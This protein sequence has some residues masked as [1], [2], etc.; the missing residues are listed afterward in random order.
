MSAGIPRP[1][2]TREA[3][4]GREAEMAVIDKAIS[5]EGHLRIVNIQGAGGIGKTSILREVQKRYHGRDGPLVTE[6]IDFFDISTH[7]WQGFLEEVVNE[8]SKKNGEP[9]KDYRKVRDR[10]DEIELAGITGPTLENARKEALEA[11]GSCYNGLAAKKRI[12]ILIDTF[13]VVQHILGKRLPEWLV[14]LE[15]TAVIIAGRRNRDW[16]DDL[17]AKVG[18]RAVDSLELKE[19]KLEDTEELFALSEAGRIISDEERRKLQRLSGGRPILLTL[20][21]YLQ[22]REA[23]SPEKLTATSGEYTLDDLKAMTTEELEQVQERFRVELVQRFMKLP[24]PPHTYIEMLPYHPVILYMGQVYK[25]FTVDTLTCLLEVTREEAQALLDGIV[26]WTFMKHDESTGSYQLHDLIRDLIVAYIWPEIDPSGD[27]RK[28]VCR[29]AVEFYG[30]LLADIEKQEAEWR[31]KRRQAEAV[32]D[33][34]QKMEARR[35]LINLKRRRQRCEAQRAYYDLIANYENGAIRYREVFVNNVWARERE[36]YKLAQ[37]ERDQ[38]MEVLGC[39]YPD[40]ERQLEDA[41]IKIVVQGEFDKGLAILESL[42]NQARREDDPHFYSD[43]LLYQGIAHT[44]KGEYKQAE[45]K[46]RDAIEV[47]E[48]LREGL[49][50]PFDS[51]N[52]ITRRVS[53]SLG[54]AYGNLGYSFSMGGRLSEAVEAYKEALRYQRIGQLKVTQAA[55]LN[56]LGFVYGRLGRYGLGKRLCEDGLEIREKL[57]LDYFIGLSYNTLGLIEYFADKP[58]RGSKRC[59][60]ALDIFERIGDPRGIGLAHRALGANLERIG[61]LDE[62]IDKLEEAESH[63]VQAE[64]VFKERGKAPEPRFFAETNERWGILYQ[65]WGIILRDRG[66][67]KSAVNERFDKAESCFKRCIEVCR[68]EKA[69]WSQAMAMERLFTL[70]FVGMKDF[71]RASAVLKEVEEIV[72]NEVPEELLL[73]A[74][75]RETSIDEIEFKRHE[76]LYPLGKMERGKG[77]LALA[78]YRKSKREDSVG[79]LSHLEEAARHYALACAYL[80]LFSEEAYALKTTLEEI[81]STIRQ[82]PM[83]EIAAFRKQVETTQHEYG[84]EGYPRLL[85]WIEDVTGL[86]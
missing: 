63:L 78:E 72:L 86:I 10:A 11:F 16:Q 29:K 22:W 68:R 84:L 76:F 20:A 8:L 35:E 25:Y 36:A 61:Q 70:Y 64:E 55:T 77:R 80:E 39:T 21:L 26:D 82:L 74:S 59:R 23:I 28:N 19:F 49:E 41:R 37:E 83:V 27:E 33:L 47:L 24:P 4:V 60:R 66:A 17:V 13:E 48:E 50:A 5:D 56:D 71:E 81:T 3:F 75:E 12:V 15:N 67:A 45:K 31:S 46:L 7:T 9:F 79:E 40:H 32:E 53:R 34:R 52:L 85:E 6:I 44:Y 51:E 2:I 73:P 30:G 18:S 43:I 69:T 42:L 58:H 14:G 57:L 1:E 62:S 54:R 38:A 65:D